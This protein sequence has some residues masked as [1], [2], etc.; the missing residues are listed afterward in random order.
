MER[1]YTLD[2]QPMHPGSTRIAL[3]ARRGSGASRHR[4]DIQSRGQ[5]WDHLMLS[6]T[7]WRGLHRSFLTSP[8]I[9]TGSGLLHRRVCSHLMPTLFSTHLVIREFVKRQPC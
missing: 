2:F 5:L 8:P 3:K 6:A 1:T 4:K 9:V 7:S